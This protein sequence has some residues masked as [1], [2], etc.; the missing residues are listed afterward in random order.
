MYTPVE[1]PKSP[2]NQPFGLLLGS[3]IHPRRHA[4]AAQLRAVQAQHLSIAAWSFAKLGAASPTLRRWW[5]D[6]RN[7]TDPNAEKQIVAPRLR[8]GNRATISIWGITLRHHPFSGE[9]WHRAHENGVRSVHLYF[10]S[11]RRLGHGRKLNPARL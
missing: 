3:E 8:L 1:P 7:H 6:G 5:S 11:L 9:W 2:P 10:I 4:R